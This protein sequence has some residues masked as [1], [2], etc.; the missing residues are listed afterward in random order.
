M[1]C[2]AS[3]CF[4]LALWSDERRLTR[5][6][7][8]AWTLNAAR[9]SGRLLAYGFHGLRV[10]VGH[11]YFPVV[12]VLYATVAVWLWSESREASRKSP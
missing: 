2:I 12:V 7:A 11:I 6:V 9:L 4:A 1:L 8:L 3:G 10:L 5:L